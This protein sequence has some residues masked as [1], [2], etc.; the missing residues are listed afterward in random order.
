M[1]A[2]KYHARVVKKL[3]MMDQVVSRFNYWYLFGMYRIDDK[4]WEHQTWLLRLELAT[5][6]Y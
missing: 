2:T 4:G 3:I 5:L 1:K 6:G